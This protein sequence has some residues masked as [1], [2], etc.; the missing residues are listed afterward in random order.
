[1]KSGPDAVHKGAHFIGATG[2]MR[3]INNA[4]LFLMA[5]SI[6]P[7]PGRLVSIQLRE[8]ILGSAWDI[9]HH[10][11]LADSLPQEETNKP[12]ETKTQMG[13]YIPGM[14]MP[15]FEKGR[16]YVAEFTV[17]F[18]GRM[19]LGIVTSAFLEKPKTIEHYPLVSVPTHG[20]LGDLDAL[21]DVFRSFIAVYDSCPFSQLGIADKSRK[22]ELQAA[23]A[24]VINSPTIIPA[25][26]NE[27]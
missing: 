13:L 4:L 14:E 9:P 23:L 17:T 12:K 5:Q 10:N 8:K 19:D 18:D 16:K 6:K 15:N 20:R 7:V 24:E 25:E 3:L 22:D 11:H 1:M 21:A 27:A 26:E 2:G